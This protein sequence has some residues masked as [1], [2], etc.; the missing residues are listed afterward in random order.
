MMKM[1]QHNQTKDTLRRL[2]HYKLEK[3]VPIDKNVMINMNS[4]KDGQKWRI[5]MQTGVIQK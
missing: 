5:S 1:K 4:L 3:Q 2:R